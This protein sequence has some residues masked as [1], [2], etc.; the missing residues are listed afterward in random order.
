MVSPIDLRAQESSKIQADTLQVL[1]LRGIAQTQKLLEVGD[2][3]FSG[4]VLKL[5]QD[6]EMILGA[7]DQSAFQLNSYAKAQLVL[8]KKGG[9]INL[10]RGSV[11]AAITQKRNRKYRLRMPA[12][13]VGVKGT[14]FH[15]EAD[16]L[17]EPN[18]SYFCLCYGQVDLQ[19]SNGEALMPLSASYHT[20]LFG[21]GDEHN[22]EIQPLDLV[23][24]HD[25]LGIKRIIEL[26][27]V[28]HEMS[29]LR[30]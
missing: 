17:G 12:L 10:E 3:I 27:N 24:N 6:S 2:Q 7:P 9:Q 29:W 14:V 18:Q 11:T 15:A 21:R 5:D 30:L 13:Q 1:A 26:G 28:P 19:G 20:A 16:W 22:T 8:E 25:D 23:T 4:E